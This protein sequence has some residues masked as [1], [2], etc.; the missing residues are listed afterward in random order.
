MLDLDRFKEINDTLGHAAGDL[1]LQEIARR[2]RTVTRESDLIARLGG[3]EFALLLPEVDGEDA[4]VVAARVSA[5]ADASID[6]DG[7]LLNVDISI[8]MAFYPRDGRNA[9]ALMPQADLAMYAAKRQGAGLAPY[10][11]SVDRRNPKQLALI[12]ELR[13]ALDRGEIVLYYQPVLALSTGEVT[14][15]EALV[16]WLHPDR[17]IVP[18]DEFIP[19]VEE[20]G[21]MQSLT[22]RVLELAL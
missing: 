12:G 10:D 18:P 22:H 11:K 7:P 8:G 4:A 21:L 2:L 3:D 14:K 13:G 5:C 15:V 6:V 19:L 17:S 16:R 1:V 20:T 9:D